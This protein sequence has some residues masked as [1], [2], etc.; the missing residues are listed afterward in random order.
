MIQLG[1]LWTVTSVFQHMLQRNGM[2]ENLD[3]YSVLF[4]QYIE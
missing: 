4:A 1:V 3:L 2:F